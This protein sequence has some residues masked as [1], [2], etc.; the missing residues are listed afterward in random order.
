MPGRLDMVLRT[1]ACI[2]LLVPGLFW[3]SSW[4]VVKALLG[5]SRERLDREYQVFARR[6]LRLAGTQLEVRGREHVKPGQSYVVVP[7]HESNWDPVALVAALAPLSI[8]F[9]IKR[10]VANVPI[11]GQALRLTGNVVVDRS[12]TRGDVDRIQRGMGQ[13]EADVSMLFYAEGTRSRK[14][15]LQ[16]FKKGAF[17]TAIEH[18]L[19]IL[20]IGHAGSYRIWQPLKLGIRKMPMTVEIGAPIPVE[21]LGADDREKLREQTFH[22]VAELRRRARERLRA[23]GHDP[24]GI[25]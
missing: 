4:A 5:A 21:G 10:Q 14:G 7:N 8:R 2:A 11:F 24:G 13:R 22:V 12:N 20:P 16:P 23:M 25:D 15:N 17:I 18:G 9:V 19:P 6:C 1:T 3:H